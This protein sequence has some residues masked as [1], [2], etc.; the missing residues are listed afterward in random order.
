MMFSVDAKRKVRKV[1]YG[2]GPSSSRESL[3]VDIGDE[4][5][6]TDCV[7][8]DASICSSPFELAVRRLAVAPAIGPEAISSIE[9]LLK[10]GSPEIEATGMFRRAL[11]YDLSALAESHE[12]RKEC[13]PVNFTITLILLCASVILLRF[14]LQV[15]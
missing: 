6:T 10:I 3:Y 1:W 14:Y 5:R 4:P 13:D 11:I 9:A 7:Y 2:A 15:M 12:H 8:D